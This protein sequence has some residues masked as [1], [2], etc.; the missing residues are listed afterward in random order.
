MPIFEVR[1][2]AAINKN[3]G[4]N[5][6]PEGFTAVPITTFNNN[7]ILDDASYDGCDYINEVDD[8][9]WYDDSTHSDYEYICD[10]IRQ[11]VQDALQLSDH[12]AAIADLHLMYDYCDTI[13]SLRFEGVDMEWTFTEKTWLECLETQ[14]VMLT[15]W[16]TGDTRALLNSRILRK[17]L[18]VM[19]RKVDNLLGRNAE[20]TDNDGNEPEGFFGVKEDELKLQIYSGH[21][22]QIDN[23]L[24]WLNPTNYELLFVPFASQITYELK[25]DDTCVAFAARDES[26]FTVGVRYNG[27]ELA[28]SGCNQGVDEYG[29]SYNDFVAYID[30][31]WY[32]GVD[33]DDLNAACFQEYTPSVAALFLQ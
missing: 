28:F 32:S 10:D 15:R 19:Q 25:Y 18:H 16:F 17:P 7:D 24:Y 22:D 9:R 3:L 20:I 11:P 27:Q 31:I 23:H 1:D 14:S 12:D 29:C 8:A 6:L 21:D 33:S 26:C 13:R 30:S 4:F 5:A 2:K